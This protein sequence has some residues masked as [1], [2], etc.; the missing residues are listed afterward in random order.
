MKKKVLLATGGTGGHVF[1]AL[2]LSEDLSDFCSSYIAL[3]SRGARFMGTG[4]E[5]FLV[6]SKLNKKNLL[7]AA[8]SVFSIARAILK[9]IFLLKKLKPDL[10]IGFG[11]YPSFPLLTAAFVTRI[12][13]VI[14]EPNSVL[15]KVNRIF[16]M[17]ALKIA[18]AYRE[19]KYL[20]KEKYKEKILIAGDQVRDSVKSMGKKNKFGSA[21]SLSLLIFGGSQGADIFTEIL[22][23]AIRILVQ[24]NPEIKVKIIQQ[25][26]ESDI[27][28]LSDFY[29]ALGVEHEIKRFFAEMGKK[30]SE[31]D[32]V[33]SRAGSSTLGE[34]KT[35]GV[36]SILVPYPYS[37]DSHQYYN[38]L[39]LEKSGGALL[40]EEKNFTPGI[41]AEKLSLFSQNKDILKDMSE[42][43]LKISSETSGNLV[44][45]IKKFLDSASGFK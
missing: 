36:P 31:A 40:F 10:V 7:E 28:G 12:P 32:L 44:L 6:D 29:A 30:Y 2:A 4:A 5:Y 19:T 37:A 15:G 38:A 27:A 11:G 25:A 1:P 42:S 45:F 18:T 39:A 24:K 34:L 20:D 14:Y 35:L 41:L 22:P 16:S 23:R 43:L 9:S 8:L 3:D 17:V 21:D 33:I 26:K 13:I